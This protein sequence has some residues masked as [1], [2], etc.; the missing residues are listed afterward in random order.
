MD[1]VP[2]A[3]D[4]LDRTQNNDAMLRIVVVRRKL[5]EMFRKRRKR[6]LGYVLHY[7]TLARTV[8]K[9]QLL[10]KKEQEKPKEMLLS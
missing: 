5:L 3:E 4:V 10:E 6:W 2:H 8:L 9:G 7:N 1:L